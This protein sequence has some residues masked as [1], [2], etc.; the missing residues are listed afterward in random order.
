MSPSV[1]PTPNRAPGSN[2]LGFD[3][4]PNAE[5][6]DPSLN[7]IWRYQARRRTR[8]LDISPTRRNPRGV[9]DNANL[10]GAPIVRRYDGR[11]PP[12]VQPPQL[13][14]QFVQPVN[15]NYL[16]QPTNVRDLVGLGNVPRGGAGV[17][18]NETPRIMEP[19]HR[20]AN[21][22]AG[23]RRRDMDTQVYIPPQTFPSYLAEHPTRFE[24][25]R[26]QDAAS[27]QRRPR[28]Q[29]TPRAQAIGGP[30]P[31]IQR[32]QQTPRPQAIG[33]VPPQIQRQPQIPPPR[34]QFRAQQQGD[35][36]VPP[37]DV[38]RWMQGSQ[39]Q[40]Q[41]GNVAGGPYDAR[42]LQ[43]YPP[44][45]PRLPQNPYPGANF[46]QATA[47]Q[48]SVRPSQYLQG[49]INPGRAPSGYGQ[50]R[51]Y[52][53]TMDISAGESAQ[54]AGSRITRPAEEE[55]PLFL[56]RPSEDTRPPAGPTGP[57]RI[58]GRH[59]P[60]G[61][62]PGHRRI[63]EEAAAAERDAER[64]RKRQ[65]PFEDESNDESMD[66][67]LL[68]AETRRQTD[69]E[70]EDDDGKLWIDCP[71]RVAAAN[72]DRR[73]KQAT[74]EALKKSKACQEE[75]QNLQQEEGRSKEGSRLKAGA[76][77]PEGSR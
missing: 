12:A 34:S 74:Q 15:Y 20:H 69:N 27:Y 24:S 50:P 61:T 7:P 5:Y 56:F 16:H 26:E 51:Y 22:R 31:Q 57:L 75:A 66:D 73:R 45:G 9:D 55:H 1:R 25:Q 28:Q 21:P 32:Q 47:T 44:Q 18:P 67:S 54:F 72:D 17:R 6:Y 33:G 77:D 30:P 64:N 59:S 19:V 8:S 14:Q 46:G 71:G 39:Q 68:E 42:F 63:R 43:G 35:S 65:R 10:V 2:E 76:K 41:Q 62:P 53:N 49:T 52:P 37:G 38:V 60:W 11:T 23:R 48:G 13:E 58:V 40:G 36:I 4:D 29:Q 70:E 3:N